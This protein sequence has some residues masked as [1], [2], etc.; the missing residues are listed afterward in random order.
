MSQI[1]EQCYMLQTRKPQ[2]QEILVLPLWNE[3]IRRM[4]SSCR[5]LFSSNPLSF[6]NWFRRLRHLK[7]T[8]AAKIFGQKY[9][10]AITQQLQTSATCG[11][12]NLTLP[13][14]YITLW[15][16][17]D[18]L[19]PPKPLSQQQ[20]GKGMVVSVD[21]FDLCGTLS[22]LGSFCCF[23]WVKCCWEDTANCLLAV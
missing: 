22:V 20:S 5:I 7:T 8:F 3:N 23:P 2:E 12:F 14:S 11:K 15:S 21:E 9:T 10:S 1:N 4:R 6:P 17:V 18:R 19:P 16:T 13:E